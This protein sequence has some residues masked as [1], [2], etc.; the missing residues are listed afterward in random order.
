MYSKRRQ[1]NP[2]A[3]AGRRVS[4]WGDAQYIERII[5]GN[6]TSLIDY[7]GKFGCF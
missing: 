1:T 7:L 4:H 2:T 3:P 6:S 5:A